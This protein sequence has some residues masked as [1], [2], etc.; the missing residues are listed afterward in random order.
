MVVKS[1]DSHGSSGSGCL[2]ITVLIYELAFCKYCWGHKKKRSIPVPIEHLGKYRPIVK[3]S[4]W[5]EI[6]G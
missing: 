6:L 1:S 3:K 5:L 4:D 2:V